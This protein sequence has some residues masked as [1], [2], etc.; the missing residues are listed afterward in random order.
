MAPTTRTRSRR[1]R[2]PGRES[3]SPRS[4]DRYTVTDD[5]FAE[6]V[7]RRATRP[8][9]PPPS[10]SAVFVFAGLLPD[11]VPPS[12]AVAAA[13]WLRQITARLG[14]S[15]G[16]QSTAG[17]RLTTARPRQPARCARLLRLAACAADRAE[18][19]YAARAGSS[20]RASVGLRAEPGGEHR[21]NIWQGSFPAQHARGRLSRHRRSTRSRPTA[22]GCTTCRQRRGALRRAFA[23]RG[24]VRDARRLRTSATTPT[25][26]L[27]G[28][29]ARRTRPT[30]RRATSAPVR[31]GRHLSS[32]E[33]RTPANARPTPANARDW[34]ARRLGQLDRVAPGTPR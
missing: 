17:D 30:A 7:E 23:R 19:E 10:A 1:P 33:R 28:C 34:G 12:R 5:R 2:G 29:P 25:A 21:A 9:P 31:G 14:A 8:S 16:P 6:F 18:W 11:T 15:E 4:I 20:R 24:R 22:T 3:A 13:P 26:T 32:A 27:P